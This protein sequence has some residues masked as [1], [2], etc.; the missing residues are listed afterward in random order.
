MDSVAAGAST[1]VELLLPLGLFRKLPLD[2]LL[3]NRL[4]FFVGLSF[5][6]SGKRRDD[7]EED[8]CNNGMN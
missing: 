7:E 3:F 1:G 4:D 8:F 2:R 6:F 5:L